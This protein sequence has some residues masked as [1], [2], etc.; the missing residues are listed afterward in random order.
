MQIG[1]IGG[2]DRNESHYVRLAEDA[3]HA[4][5]FHTGRLDGRG[6][7]QLRSLV[8]RSDLVI[9]VTDVNSHGAVQ[10]ARRVAHKAG[11]PVHIARRVGP[12]A[13]RQLLASLAA[14][15]SVRRSATTE[16]RAARPAA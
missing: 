15:P 3:G 1:W 7:D 11:K 4:L 2:L 10:L 9:V 6:S 8:E 13:F 14:A 12:S 5:D 16:A